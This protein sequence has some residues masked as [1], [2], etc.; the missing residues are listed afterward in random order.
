MSA[1]NFHALKRNTHDPI[2]SYDAHVCAYSPRFFR[3]LGLVGIFFHAPRRERGL[4][5]L[6]PPPV[7]NTARTGYTIATAR[8]GE[9]HVGPSVYLPYRVFIKHLIVPLAP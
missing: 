7:T 8:P 2:V 9:G 4:R 5:F 6:P 1:W 3:L